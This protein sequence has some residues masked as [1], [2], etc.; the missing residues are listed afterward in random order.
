MQRNKRCFV[1]YPTVLLLF[2]IGNFLPAV[3]GELSASAAWELRFLGVDDTAK[4]SELCDFPKQRRVALGVVG[5]G[6]ISIKRMKK[7]TDQGNT[8]TYHGCQDSPSDTHDDGQLAVILDITSALGVMVDL[9]IWQPGQSFKDVADCFRQAGAV[10]DVVCLFQSFWGPGTAL[11]TD[12]IRESPGAL[13][14]SPY[15]EVGDPTSQTP[16]GSACKPWDPGSIGHFV[17]A[18]PLARNGKPGELLTPSDRDVNDSEAVNF[19]APSYHAS[20]PGGTCPAGAT[21]TACAVYLYA[22]LAEKQGPTAVINI[23]R[24]TSGIDRALLKN[25]GF[26]EV[27]IDQLKKKIAILN[28]PSE[29]KQRKLDAAGILS[30]YGAFRKAVTPP[31]TAGG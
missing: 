26:D 8:L 5:Q 15:V 20:G 11:I 29:G 21:T 12:A 17:T 3:G 30:L 9:H 14:V 28:V 19:I 2:L 27:A 23:L 7:Y 13:F 22:V 10:T 1:A 4:L 18:I 6:G 24:E 31:K 25:G 16:Q